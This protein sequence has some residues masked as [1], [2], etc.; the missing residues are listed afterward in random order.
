MTFN[1]SEEIIVKGSKVF[2]YVEETNELTI[3][4]E[5]LKSLEDLIIEFKLSS[6]K[7]VVQMVQFSFDQN[8]LNYDFQDA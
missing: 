3:E 2:N 1:I 8:V 7:S 6:A 5:Y 4:L